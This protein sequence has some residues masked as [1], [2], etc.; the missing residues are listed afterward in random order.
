[1]LVKSEYPET[2]IIIGDSRRM[3]ELKDESAHLNLSQQGVFE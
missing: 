2:T 3:D 1:M